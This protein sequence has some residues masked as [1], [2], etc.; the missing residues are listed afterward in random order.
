[1]WICRENLRR[2]T[3]TP[4]LVP[5]SCRR[6]HRWRHPRKRLG[7]RLDR[8]GK[9]RSTGAA[10]IHPRSSGSIPSAGNDPQPVLW[11]N[12]AGHGA[13]TRTSAAS[14]QRADQWVADPGTFAKTTWDGGRLIL[15]HANVRA[16]IMPHDCP[17]VE[18]G[19]SSPG[20]AQPSKAAAFWL[21]PIICQPLTGPPSDRRQRR[22]QSSRSC[23]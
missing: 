12:Q 19:I 21:Q 10:I 15:T 4:D 3:F 20:S 23:D 11:R 6:T 7:F 1:M 9:P 2:S 18:S 13:A 16:V 14:V 22:Y 17:S 5:K 8:M